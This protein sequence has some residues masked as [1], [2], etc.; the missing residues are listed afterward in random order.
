MDSNSRAISLLIFV[1]FASFAVQKILLLIRLDTTPASFH[2][3]Y[4]IA[5]IELGGTKTVVAVGDKEGALLKQHRFPTT[6]PTETFAQAIDWIREQGEITALGVGS[7]GP[8]GINPDRP[9]YGYILD[10]PKERWAHYDLLAELYRRLPEIPIK[11]DTDVNAAVLAES[12]S[13]SL[14]ATGNLAYITIGTG[15]GAG[16]LSEGR[17]L[18]GALH[19][20]FG[21]LRI[22]RHP[23]D[24]FA[25]LCNHHGDCLEGL[26]SGPAMTKR[27]GRPPHE[28]PTDDRAWDIEAWYL[29][30][31][32]LA[33]LAIASPSKVIIGGGVSQAEGFHDKVDAQ[34]RALAGEYFAPL[35]DLTPYVSP[36]L[37]EQD[38][39]I[40][41]ALLLATQA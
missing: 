16:I 22:P 19:S 33:L 14:D 9:D 30:H 38:A 34:L 10:T 4:V 1:L 18:H 24:D 26:A 23:E 41:G 39:G 12:L 27:W 2:S 28:I 7:F 40:R 36:P 6:T 32:V 3:P 11:L 8:V 29:A 25:G 37:L 31:G 17:L 15:I 35:N 20:E 21:H 5:G 13:D